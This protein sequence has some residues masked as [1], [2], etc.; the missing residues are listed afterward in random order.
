MGNNQ[1][2][3]WSL[4]LNLMVAFVNLALRSL[5]ALRLKDLRARGLR[6][7]RSFTGMNCLIQLWHI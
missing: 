6:K 7:R 1:L 2:T 4:W 3:G 5:I